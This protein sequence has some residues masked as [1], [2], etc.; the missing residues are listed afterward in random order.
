MSG[1][2][3]FSHI[4]IKYIRNYGYE[5]YLNDLESLN[6]ECIFIC[7]H[8]EVFTIGKNHKKN[9]II[10]Q[11][12]E[13]RKIYLKFL[14][15][16][17][18]GGKATYH[19][20]GQIVLYPVIN[21][22]IRKIK[23][24]DFIAKLHDVATAFLNDVCQNNFQFQAEPRNPGIYRLNPKTLNNEKIVSIGLGIK[25]GFI[26][27]GIAIN[28]SN[29]LNLPKHII[30]CGEKNRKFTS[31]KKIYPDAI[32]QYISKKGTEFL[33]KIEK[34]IQSDNIQK[35]EHYYGSLILLYHFFK[36]FK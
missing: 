24:G 7:D 11:N 18:R 19:E 35:D 9:D 12:E 36:S 16:I 17:N 23:L 10:F 28:F 14:Y 32:N 2:D 4:S 20:P 21:I 30:S 29:E 13:S 1:L 31:L 15:K 5:N 27:H 33:K 8:Q 22:K 3:Q 6:E 34:C 26:Q 25:N